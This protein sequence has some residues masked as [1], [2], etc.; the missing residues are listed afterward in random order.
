MIHGRRT[1]QHRRRGKRGQ[2]DLMFLEGK[3]K[4]LGHNNAGPAQKLEAFSSSKHAA[5]KDSVNVLQY[6]IQL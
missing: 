6:S 4:E 3:S 5:D 1:E 2:K